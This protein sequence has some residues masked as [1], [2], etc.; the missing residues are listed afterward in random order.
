[1]YAPGAPHTEE[2]VVRA[3]FRTIEPRQTALCAIRKP[4]IYIRHD[5]RDFELKTLRTKP[6]PHGNYGDMS[7]HLAEQHKRSSDRQSLT[8]NALEVVF[9][10]PHRTMTEN[11]VFRVCDVHFGGKSCFALG[12][13][14]EVFELSSTYLSRM[15][16]IHAEYKYMLKIV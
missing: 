12:K 5:L 8:N 15:D 11:E 14:C 9:G 2:S 7:K 10:F 1:M 13:R 4:F 3:E 16:K 6:K